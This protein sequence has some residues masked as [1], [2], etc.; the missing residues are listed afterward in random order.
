MPSQ[1]PHSLGV[2]GHLAID[3]IIHPNFEIGSSPG[4]SAAA[5]AT[6]SVQFGLYTSI[7]SEVG[8]DFPKE[9]LVVLENLGV[10][11]LNIEFSDKEESLRVKFRYDGE[12]GLENIE[13]NDRALTELKIKALPKTECVH[14]CPGQP[15]DQTELVQNLKGGS[16]ILSISFSD[17]FTDDYKKKGFLDMI[18]WK[19]IEV[20]FLNE[21]EGR[22]MTKEKSPEDMARKF[23]DEGPKVVV[24]TLGEK[25]SLVYDGRDMHHRNARDVEVI[26]PTGCGD[27][28]IGGFLGEYLVSKDI[29]KAA[30]IGTY[31]ASLTAQKKG[32]WAALLSDG[33]RF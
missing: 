11:I 26:D 19:D 22:A 31:M 4:G 5:I 14:I 30:G 16:R 25:G 23:H 15:K 27:S 18:N 28:Y 3:N 6:A 12:G 21:I 20:L 32:S 33:R 7:Y 13:C 2:V 24:I 29:Q 1:K 8:K 9:W 10:D 17:Y